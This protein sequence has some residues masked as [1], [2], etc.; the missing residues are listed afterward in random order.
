MCEIPRTT[1]TIKIILLY[2]HILLQ[3][4]YEFDRMYHVSLIHSSYRLIS[5]QLFRTVAN[6]EKIRE[7]NNS[8]FCTSR[9]KNI[10]RL[11]TSGGAHPTERTRHNSLKKKGTSACSAGCIPSVTGAVQKLRHDVPSPRISA[12][13]Q[14]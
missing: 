6:K 9:T 4:R 14:K 10:L 5:E 12:P 11:S 8:L 1:Y 2:T 3:R 7:K 13:S